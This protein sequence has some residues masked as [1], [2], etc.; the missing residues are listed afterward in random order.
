MTER[1]NGNILVA[2]VISVAIG[3]GVAAAGSDGSVAFAGF[4]LFA[5]CGAL[6]FLIN[7]LVFLPSAAARTEKFYDLTGGLTYLSVTAFA[8]YAAGTL[9]L[10][11]QIVAALV[12]VWAVRLASFLFVRISKDGKD[13]RFDDIKTRPLR[14]LMAWTLQGLWVLL[15]AACALAII[16]S[17][18][19]VP[20]ELIGWLGLGVW[21]VGFLIEAI[22]D[23]QK[24]KFKADP[25]N[26]GKFITTGLW[27]WSRHPNYFGEITLW[28]GV[29]IMALPVLSGWQWVTLISPVFVT[30]LLTKV[31]GIPL[32]EQRAEARWGE[33]PEFRRY[34]DSTSVLIPLPPKS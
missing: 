34:T 10:R 16:T 21:V 20:M 14:F 22:S 23:H 6:A 25:G 13:G 32:L 11:G 9:D 17:A 29:A 12:I 15:T 3:A 28:T 24:S 18:R 30:F 26:E 31:S 1:T 8:V 2:I 5:L 33:D 19:K 4:P 7:W 27:S